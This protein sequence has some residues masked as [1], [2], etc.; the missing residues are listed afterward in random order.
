MRKWIYPQACYA[1][2]GFV[3][4]GDVKE[5]QNACSLLTHTRF[6][7]FLR[8]FENLVQSFDHPAVGQ[9]DAEIRKVGRVL[10][11]CPFIDKMVDVLGPIVRNDVQNVIF[12]SCERSSFFQKGSFWSCPVQVAEGRRVL[13]EPFIRIRGRHLKVSEWECDD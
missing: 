6:V 13:L 3:I 10:R 9:I 11:D 2:Y 4:V 1:S 12:R 7:D 8:K 5:S